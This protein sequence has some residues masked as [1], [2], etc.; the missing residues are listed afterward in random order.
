[1][2]TPGL[3]ASVSNKACQLMVTFKDA[4][5]DNANYFGQGG[6]LRGEKLASTPVEK[7]QKQSHVSFGEFASYETTPVTA[8]HNLESSDDELYQRTTAKFVRGAEKYVVMPD[9][10][11]VLLERINI[12][13]ATDDVAA[14]IWEAGRCED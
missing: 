11:C 7:K 3:V 10:G 2:I 6:L 12:R 13:P 9:G 5:D 8:K 4:D 1:V 14:L